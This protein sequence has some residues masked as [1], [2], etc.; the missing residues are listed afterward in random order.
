MDLP[1][2]LTALG[3]LRFT[4]QVGLALMGASGLWG[5]V[6]A[7]QA[8]RGPEGDREGARGITHMLV[9]ISLIGFAL[10]FLAWLIG[11]FVVFPST[12]NAHEG[13]T[14]R[15]IPR[16]HIQQGVAASIPFVALTTIVVI[17]G[18]ILY[19][20][21]R[22][23]FLRYAREYFMSQFILVS[24]L[25]FFGVFS[26]GLGSTQFYYF[27]HG[28]HSIFTVGT[29]IVVDL[30]YMGTL[31]SDAMR[32]MLYRFFPWLS[33]SIWIGLGIDQL[34]NIHLYSQHNWQDAQ[35]LMTQIVVGIIIV[36]GTLLSGR[37]NEALIALI[38]EDGTVE[39]FN[40]KT[41]RITGLS[42]AISLTSWLTITFIDYFSLTIGPLLF[43]GVWAAVVFMLF[44][45]RKPADKI[46]GR[47]LAPAATVT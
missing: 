2:G 5:M 42:G 35:F 8:S 31:A 33:K 38:R 26:G 39:H 9:R 16:E 12:V 47:F 29:V 32:R 22:D 7:R 10:F 20:R 15:D 46:L 23:T 11:V 19:R 40:A 37:M 6:F 34:N 13:I 44:S 41:E 36:N 4:A 21:H 14:I 17:A 28:W 25:M 43:F 30:L 24:G 45:S 3:L 18:L 27:F 1:F